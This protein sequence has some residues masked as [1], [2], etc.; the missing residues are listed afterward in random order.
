MRRP[1]IRR[2]HDVLGAGGNIASG[3]RV[4]RKGGRFKFDHFWFS[5]EK[6][7]DIV[8]RTVYVSDPE[9]VFYS[10]KIR[11]DQIDNTHICYA[12]NEYKRD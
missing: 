6:L 8:G 4:V 3:I 7:K 11:V 5:H 12:R 2:E 9:D 1:R 10:E